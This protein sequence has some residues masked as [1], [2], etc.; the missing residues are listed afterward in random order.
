MLKNYILQNGTT[1][2]WYNSLQ[3]EKLVFEW[4][5]ATEYNYKNFVRHISIENLSNNHL[6]IDIKAPYNLPWNNNYTSWGSEIINNNNGY[7]V[8][9]LDYSLGGEML[10]VEK[11]SLNKT[12]LIL[13]LDDNPY[14]F[15]ILD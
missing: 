4:I 13:N 5:N 7:T 12:K 6:S 3:P 9:N 15:M 11:I 1:E 2:D 8:D 10:I 14:I